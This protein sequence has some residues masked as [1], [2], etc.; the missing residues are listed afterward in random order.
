MEHN[1][2]SPLS[3]C[4]LRTGCNVALRHGMTPVTNAFNCAHAPGLQF[5]KNELLEI[6]YFY[7]G[8]V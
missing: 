5:V 4:R 3:G 8:G 1:D 6:T 2:I 7:C